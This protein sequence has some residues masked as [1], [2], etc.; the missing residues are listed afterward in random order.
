MTRGVLASDHRPNRAVRPFL[1][2]RSLR[3]TCNLVA[4][5][6]T[7]LLPTWRKTSTCPIGRDQ[8]DVRQNQLARVASIIS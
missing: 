1:E 8:S 4:T 7:A 5:S 6:Y 3:A 2:P